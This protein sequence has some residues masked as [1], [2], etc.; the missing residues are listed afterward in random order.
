MTSSGPGGR[1]PEVP[2]PGGSRARRAAEERELLVWLDQAPAWS[3]AGRFRDAAW[4]AVLDANGPERPDA[5]TGA[6]AAVRSGTGAAGTGTEP[7]T[8]SADPRLAG[9]E[10]WPG[11]A[12]FTA[13]FARGREPERESGAVQVTARSLVTGKVCPRCGHSFRIGELVMIGGLENDTLTAE[14]ADGCPSAAVRA[15][16]REREVQHTFTAVLKA[17]FPSE[18]GGSPSRLNAKCLGLGLAYHP[19][20]RRCMLCAH[21]LRIGE[22]VVLCPCGRDPVACGNSLHDDPARGLDCLTTWRSMGKWWE[23]CRS[24]L[25]PGQAPEDGR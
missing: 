4:Q 25:R 15:T 19:H 1:T 14:H 20:R 23:S 5:G 13:G 24:P 6:G 16:P 7:P 10:D 11:L 2:V 22:R 12:A 8:S 18:A 21:T 17:L 3:P 9:L